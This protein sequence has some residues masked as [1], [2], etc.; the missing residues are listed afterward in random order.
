MLRDRSPS[1]RTVGQTFV[2][3]MQSPKAVAS[4]SLNPE[5]SLF[6][7]SQYQTT[8]GNPMGLLL[9]EHVLVGVQQV[10]CHAG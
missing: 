8:V 1:D 9:K 2:A 5:R 4:Q 7:I 6:L 3:P 10:L